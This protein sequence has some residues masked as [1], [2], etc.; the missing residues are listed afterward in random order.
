MLVEIAAAFLEE[1]AAVL[2]G[3][4]SALET[5][6]AAATERW[7]HTIKSSFR[8]FGAENAHNVAQAIEELARAGQLDDVTTRLSEL[9]TAVV[10]IGRQL[11]RVV[12]TGD[13]P[14]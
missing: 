9:E 12:E 3:L 7:A 2:S 13:V 4:H 1:S 10:E 6:D 5:S 8:T 14:T 11:R